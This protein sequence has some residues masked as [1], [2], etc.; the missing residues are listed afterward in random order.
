MRLVP[1]PNYP[2]L[3]EAYLES[4]ARKE[5][6]PEEI[7]KPLSRLLRKILDK[8]AIDERTNYL[9]LAAAI[10]NEIES[11]RT[12]PGFSAFRST[13]Q[14]IPH[15]TDTLITFTG[16]KYNLD[17]WT[18]ETMWDSTATAQR[19]YI[20]TPG[21]Y[22]VWAT[23]MWQQDVS[24]TRSLH[25]NYV[26]VTGA[27]TAVID[28]HISLI[29]EIT[30]TTDSGH[31][32]L[33]DPANALNH[34][35]SSH[36]VAKVVRVEEAGSYFTCSVLQAMTTAGSLNILGALDYSPSFGAQYIGAL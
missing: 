24:G 2:A 7:V 27:P 12:T 23:A 11:A 18:D 16:S 28:N 34:Y 1:R 4:M 9:W 6:I 30:T 10:D 25:I 22:L 36:S 19:G 31:S 17:P 29:P 20:R 21:V 32:H 14:S 8:Q 33:V 26:P 3:S 35:N 5:R 15:N 13:P